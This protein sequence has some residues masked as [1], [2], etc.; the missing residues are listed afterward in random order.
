MGYFSTRQQSRVDIFISLI[1]FGVSL[2]VL[3]KFWGR[4]IITSS[5]N[6]HLLLTMFFNRLYLVKTLQ[7]TIMAFV[8]SPIFDDWNVVT[9]DFIRSIVIGLDGSSEH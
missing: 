3:V 8:E 4:D 2:I 7:S 6:L 1:I 5:P 9:I